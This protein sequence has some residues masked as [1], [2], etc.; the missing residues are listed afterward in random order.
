[1]TMLFNFAATMG[2]STCQNFCYEPRIMYNAKKIQP[3]KDANISK[4]FSFTLID[5]PL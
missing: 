4:L 3:Q 1:M 5:I 2:A